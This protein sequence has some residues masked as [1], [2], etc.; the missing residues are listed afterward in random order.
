VAIIYSKGTSLFFFCRYI[1]HFIILFF[2]RSELVFL[3]TYFYAGMGNPILVRGA[4][5]NLIYFKEPLDLLLYKI[6]YLKRYS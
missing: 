6:Y 1:F 2:C 3:G 5:C 4:G